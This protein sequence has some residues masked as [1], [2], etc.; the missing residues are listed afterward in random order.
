MRACRGEHAGG[1]IR[2]SALRRH[3]IV[4]SYA[5]HPQGRNTR[6]TSWTAFDRP[7]AVSKVGQ[8][9]ASGCAETLAARSGAGDGASSVEAKAEL[10]GV[11]FVWL[12]EATKISECYI[13]M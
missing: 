3:G 7:A 13:L 2:W 8:A 4:T 10:V 11:H 12:L 6:R 9:N 1:L 5:A